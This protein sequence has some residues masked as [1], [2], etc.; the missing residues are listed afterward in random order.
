MGAKWSDE[1][2]EIVREIYKSTLSIEDQVHLLPGRTAIGIRAEA[3]KLRVHKAHHANMSHSA[4]AV[5]VHKANAA[6]AV[7]IDKATL[8]AQLGTSGGMCQADLYRSTGI[9]KKR[10][11][12]LIAEMMKAEQVHIRDYGSRFNSAVFVLGKGENAVRPPPLTRKELRLRHAERHGLDVVM[13]EKEKE[14]R[15]DEMYR[16]RECSWW[17]QAD[18]VVSNAMRA[19]VQM[20]V[21]A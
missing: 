9:D 18:P 17:P 5:A 21:S 16:E 10:I 6:R 13:S 19:M 2:R 3:R 11:R 7:E 20:G 15:R 8:A 14:R 12:R 1:E 4:M